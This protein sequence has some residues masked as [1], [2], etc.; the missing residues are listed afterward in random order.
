[1]LRDFELDRSASLSLNDRR[2]VAQPAADAQI[3][4]LQTDE[5]A[6][7]QF[8]VDRQI[9]HRKFAPARLDLKAGPDIPNFLWL[10][11]AL[12]AYEA[13]LVPGRLMMVSLLTDGLGHGR[14]LRVRPLPPQRPAPS[15]AE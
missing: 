14:D 11:G 6:P 4:D 5:V 2:A 8:A 1:L 13:S 3:I 10:E 9:E 12:L 15:W 7:P